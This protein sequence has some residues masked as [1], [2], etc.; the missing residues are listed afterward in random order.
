MREVFY[1]GDIGEKD[2]DGRTFSRDLMHTDF[3][4]PLK[5]VSFVCADLTGSRFPRI[6]RNC[7]FTGAN[8]FGADMRSSDLSGSVFDG[9]NMVEAQLERAT[10]EAAHSRARTLL[11]P[12]LT[13][14]Y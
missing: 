5:G 6:V 9:A 14:P 10:L 13:I 8:L 11:T 7:N 2:G 12:F 4:M 3:R 1:L